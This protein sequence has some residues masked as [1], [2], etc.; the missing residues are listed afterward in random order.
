MEGEETPIKKI[1]KSADK[2]AYIKERYANNKEYYRMYNNTLKVKQR[3]DIDDECISNYKH[4]LY[5][6]VKMKIGRAHV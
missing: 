6:V 4:Y 1:K 5:N 3:Y 2:N